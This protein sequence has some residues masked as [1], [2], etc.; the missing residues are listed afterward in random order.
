MKVHMNIANGYKRG[1]LNEWFAD[2]PNSAI[3]PDARIAAV[4]AWV[5]QRYGNWLSQQDIT[6]FTL[7]DVTTNSFRV[8]FLHDTDAQLF[9]AQ[10]G[11]RVVEE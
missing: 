6:D 5:H 2:D 11:G 3:D 8:D 1:E 7:F 10:I 9:V 4:T